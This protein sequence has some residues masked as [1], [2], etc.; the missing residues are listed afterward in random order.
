M[1]GPA[2]DRDWFIVSRWQEYGAERRANLLRVLAIAVFYLVHLANYHRW[3]G[4]PEMPGSDRRFHQLMTALA[5]AWIA[6]A[7][8]I[9][10]A[11][12]REFFPSAMKYVTTLADVVLL[13]LVIGT[14]DGPR[15]PLVVGYFLILMVV[16]L[17][18]SLRLVWCGTAAVVAGYLALLADARWF[19]VADKSV[20]AHTAM[21]VLVAL[22]FGGVTLGAVVRRVRRMAFEFAARS[23]SARLSEPSG[24]R[25]A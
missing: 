3:F 6:T 10:V 9:R 5:A 23:S 17:R 2:L 11:L 25:P 12:D 21:I 22:V 7:L 16:A 19:A 4:L 13:T 18:F 1:D 15:S 14:A 24:R 8:A 20:P